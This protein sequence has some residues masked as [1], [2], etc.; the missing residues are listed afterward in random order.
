MGINTWRDSSLDRLFDDIAER[1]GERVAIV[2][3]EKRWTYREVQQHANAIAAQLREMGVGRE[4]P[5]ATFAPRSAELITAFVGILK[6]GGCYAPLDAQAPAERLAH[7]LADTAAPVVIA[8]RDRADCLPRGSTRVLVLEDLFVQAKGVHYIESANGPESLAC[9]MYTSG[10]TGVPK[11]AL[12]EHRG[13]ARLVRDQEYVR[14]DESQVFLALA[15]LSFDAS[16]FEI[17]GAL[18][19][20]ATVAVVS[21]DIPSLA[22]IV[23]AIR[24]YRVTTLWVT[25]GLFNAM[26]DQQL[27]ALAEVPQVL[28]GG[29]VL[30]RAHV[31]RFLDAA[32]HSA[33]VN[34]YGPTEA[35]TFTCCYRVPHDHPADQPV[36]IGSVL[37][38]TTAYI[39]DDGELYIGGDGVARGYLN[40]PELTKEKFV[41]N[42]F[43][44]ERGG[45]LYRTGDMV[46]R[47][48]DGVLE[49]HGRVDRQVKI[50]GFRV[51]PGEIEAAINRIAGVRDSVVSVEEAG[52][53]KRLVAYVVGQENA[54][55]RSHLALELP[56]WSIPAEFLFVDELPL[57]TNGKV[58]RARL[59]KPP[60]AGLEG[61]LQAIWARML[62][63]DVAVHEN[64]FDLGGSSLQMLRIH[65]AIEQDLGHKL[66]I[67]DLF[68]CPTIHSVAE[69]L[70]QGD[71]QPRQGPEKKFSGAI[72][73]VGMAARVPGAKSV[74]EYWKNLL[75]GVG[76][77]SHFSEEELETGG[78]ATRPPNWVR[79]RSVMDDADRFDAAYFNIFPKEAETMDPQHRVFLECSASALD[80]A[81]YDPSAYKGSI[82]VFAGCSPN[83]YFL[84][85]LCS[86]PEFVERYTN[87]YQVGNYGAMLGA[88][89]DFLA[90]RVSYKLN[91]RGPAVFVGTACST[92]LVA[93]CLACESLLNRQCDMALAGGVSIT[94]PQ[95]RGY[96]HQEGGI[97][98]AD[99]YC[100]PFDAD[101]RG[102]V[103]GSGCGVVLLKRLEDAITD[104]DH[105]WAVIRGFALNNDGSGRA[106]FTAPSVNGQAEVIRMAQDAAGVNAETIGYVEAHGT[107]TPLGDPIEIA[108]LTQAFRAHTDKR[109]YCAVGSAK[110]NVGHLDAAAGIAGLIKT[111]LVLK[112][113]IIPPTLNFRKPNPRID[114]ASSPFFVNDRLAAWPDIDGPRRAGVSAFGVGGTNAHVVMEQP[115]ALEPAARDSGLQ[116]LP[117]S[118]R[119]EAAVEESASQLQEHLRAW[120]NERIGDVA[121]TLQTGR[122][123][124]E[125][126]RA[127]VAATVAEAM[128]STRVVSGRAV[129]DAAVAF[130]FPGQGAQYP[131]MARELYERERVF[132][133][134]I[135]RCTELLRARLGCD[136]KELMFRAGE[137]SAPHVDG[138]QALD[139]TAMTQPALFSVEYA[140]AQL[141]IS[142]GVRPAAMIGHSVG[143][144]VAA[145][146]AGVFSLEDALN[147]VAERGRLMQQLPAGAMLSVRMSEADVAPLLGPDLSIA[148]VNASG[149]CVISGPTEAIAILEKRL[150][151]RVL[152]TS[153]AFHSPMMDPILSTFRDCVRAAQPKPPALPYISCLTGDWIRPEQATDPEYWARHLRE[154]VRFSQG[155]Q[156]MQSERTHV[157]LEVGPGRT[158][159]TLA[160]Q[161]SMAAI[162]SIGDAL[163]G[164]SDCLCLMTAVARLWVTGIEPDWQALHGGAARYRVPLPTYPF[165]RSRY[166]IEPALL[167]NVL[168]RQSGSAES[169]PP[170][171]QSIQNVTTK[172]RLH[173][174][175]Q[176]LFEELAGAK[177]DASATG[178]TFLEMGFDS[179]LLAQAAKAIEQKFGTPIRFA[180]LL[181]EQSTFA[182]LATWLEQRVAPELA[183]APVAPVQAASPS[184]LEALLRE[185]VSAFTALMNKQLEMLN[186]LNPVPTA[187]PEP[188]PEPA[189]PVA[190]QPI[191]A[192]LTEA[193]TEIRLSAQ[194]GEEESCAYNE[195]LIVRLT[196]AL[197]ENALRQALK[198]NALRQ[199]LDTVIQRHEALRATL[200]DSGDMLICHPQLHIEV[201]LADISHLPAGERESAIHNIA[202]EEARRPFDL[203]RGPLVRARMA[204]L[205]AREHVLLL[206]IHHIICDGWSTNIILREIAEAY[207]A[208]CEGRPC[209][210][211]EPARFSEY[212][213]SEKQLHRGEEAQKV[214]SYWIKEF[215]LPAP[216]LDLPTDRPRPAVKSYRGA[217]HRA[218]IDRASCI[219]I[220][221][222]AASH[223][224]TLFGMLLAGFNALLYRLTRQ[225]DL[226]VGIPIAA[227]SRMPGGP[228]VGHCVNFLPIRVNLDGA[229]TGADLLAQCRR[230]LIESSDYHSYT[231]GTLVRKLALP[232]DPGRLPLIEV[233]FNHFSLG[234]GAAG[235]LHF[236]GLETRVEQTGKAFVNFD[237]FVNV[238]DTG[239]GLTIY[240]DYNT[241]LFDQST[242]ERWLSHYRVLLEGLAANP[243][244]PVSRLP[245]L[246]PE[247]R[248]LIIHEWNATTAEYPRHVC[249]HE[250]FEAQ[251]ISVPQRVAVKFRGESLTYAELNRRAD[252]LAAELQSAGIGR[253]TLA[254]ICLEPSIE[255]LVAVLAVLK[256]GGAYVPLDPSYPSD[257][258]EFIIED[259]GVS[260][261][262][263]TRSGCAHLQTGRARILAVD[264]L[265]LQPGATPRHVSKPEDR[266][267]VIYTSGS[268]GK[269]K[270][271]EV[272]HR[273]LV[274]FLVSMQ[275][276]PGMNET[277][278]LLAVTTLSFDIAGLELLLPLSVGARVVIATRDTTRD[279][280][281]LAALIAAESITV[282]QATPSTWKLLLAAEWQGQPGIK[283]LCGGEEMPRELANSLVERSASLWNMYGPTE[284]TI[285]S[286][287][288]RVEKGSGSVPVGRPIANTQFYV[289]DANAQ[290]V[291]VGVPGELYI[292]GDGVAR[293][294]LNRP[295]LTRERFVTNPFVNDPVARMYR[296]GDLVRSRPDGLLE[297]LGR[298]DYQVKIRG[299]RIELGEI[300]TLLETY[301]P[302][303]DS[304]VVAR[305]DEPGAKRLVGYLVPSSRAHAL[306]TA[307]VKRFLSSRLPDYMVPSVFVT[308]EA[309]PLT[310]NGKID[311]RA[312]LAMPAPGA[313][314]ADHVPP[315][316]ETETTLAGIW[317]EVLHA[318][319]VGI[320]DDLFDLGADSIHIFQI[321]ARCARAGLNV[322]PRDLLRRRTVAELAET[323]EALPSAKRTIARVSRENFRGR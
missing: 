22:D 195:G 94:F 199:A 121:F 67:T 239:D 54:S 317:S 104:R 19:N 219:R 46:R 251:A 167:K 285:W 277:D 274:N 181:D 124:F 135:D 289:L 248:E 297:F 117:I 315:R 73:V 263:S 134:A 59:A 311:R 63:H 227:Q 110:G 304:A 216:L 26:V 262:L 77:I 64:F 101:A 30:S 87:E 256:S 210:L 246:A 93:T 308:L 307:E 58:D 23:G 78:A 66:A 290:P 137:R 300:E 322:A 205:S 283:L 36:P 126:R 45:R 32:P 120:P 151:G 81:G 132:R 56:A 252:A 255:M 268:T 28:A 112:H 62:G 8:S 235:D 217:T 138:E 3:G 306:D 152:R 1:Y 85:N 318:E 7:V 183:P 10:S 193:Q 141:W 168:L 61:R 206:S 116:V 204:R 98:S 111:A 9:I 108:G 264:E 166:W 267:Y 51:E 303:K 180:Q 194:L 284:T 35:T 177:L 276:E 38:H 100:R 2:D 83:T 97:V 79:A 224:S 170:M 11:G 280:R 160:R 149:S 155:L 122:R 257:R 74:S 282:M 310:P 295:E 147:L 125:Y 5:V 90:T 47:R 253:D 144:F 129:K 287:V 221:K 118:A 140:L 196:G 190:N 169:V 211:P 275:R 271:V 184:N 233:Q 218:H 294:Y 146:L 42:T 113:G 44:P 114:F 207:N 161:H 179:L 142:F 57:T 6:A 314:V 40:A 33:L 269:P 316:N 103:F 157:L 70:E 238:A 148:A 182:T 143:E 71:A 84:R 88:S 15:P 163:E 293:G 319:R 171:N 241:D 209:E 237:L 119:S 68:R 222:A 265:R 249:A 145:C 232:R 52:G 273:N 278:S 31:R 272:T 109:Q 37:N 156:R 115:P 201:P 99:G 245:I 202:D 312:L 27:D 34:G 164:V 139:Q 105:I 17:W 247:E 175:V 154:T 82:G 320:H 178:T 21:A 24:R 188:E 223:G 291:P 266:A 29:D 254:G 76:S 173:D 96:L 127:I 65:A 261:L 16:T 107:G 298:L 162:A 128:D 150:Q 191:E 102:T 106:G 159:T 186:A 72:A 213:W 208:Q 131:G 230:K 321:C 229:P 212:A 214:E 187:K 14:F 136:L 18:L 236:A 49:F 133:G 299:H 53:E 323:L 48:A 288:L 292:G 240:C 197:K 130:L 244:L 286:S 43:E 20:G 270:G 281:Q 55:L 39:A 215:D 123:R 279:G 165:E 226:V 296:T 225:T 50:R 309:M 89:P 13:I 75:E 260:V 80:D 92:S 60:A 192:P 313:A 203:I 305:E 302:L 86:D 231:Y 91:L 41:A 234:K 189:A 176:V 4:T 242:I 158:L 200:T 220:R 243:A 185:Q 301:P 198:E 228:L 259:A 172:P 25:S 95:K 153:H 69:L 12:I 258:I 250:L 174:A